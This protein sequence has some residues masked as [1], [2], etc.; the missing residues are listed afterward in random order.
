MESFYIITNQLKDRDYSVTIEIKDYIERKG[1]R[2]ILAQKDE[3]GFIVPGTIPEN[4]DCGL[5]LGGDGTLIRAIRDLEGNKLPLLGINQDDSDEESRPYEVGN[6]ERETRAHNP[7][8]KRGADIGSHDDGDG[9]GQ[10][11]QTGIDKRYR[12][13]GSGGRRLYRGCNKRTG[14]D[15]H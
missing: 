9:L 13:Y 2:V 4:V 7:C 3:E 11:E 6:V 15:A 8:R 12:H 14:K 1:K 10:S 5:V